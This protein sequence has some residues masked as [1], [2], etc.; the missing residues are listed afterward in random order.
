MWRARCFIGSYY[1]FVRP[2]VLG[3]EARGTVESLRDR[4]RPG[5]AYHGPTFRFELCE[6]FATRGPR[7]TKKRS[8]ICNSN[9]TKQDLDGR[10][11]ADEKIRRTCDRLARC[12]AQLA[13][14]AFG[15]QT[16]QTPRSWT[17]HVASYWASGPSIDARSKALRLSAER[18][19]WAHA[20]TAFDDKQRTPDARLKGLRNL[21]SVVRGCCASEPSEVPPWSS[22]S[23]RWETSEE[24]VARNVRESGVVARIAQVAKDDRRALRSGLHVIMLAAQRSTIAGE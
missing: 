7:E 20:L 23:T 10:W 2:G 6:A 9:N 12:L 22:R 11:D 17:Q 15:E 1:A 21:S 3:A 24:V 8:I 14:D 16:Q 5:R 13:P 4:L 18:F 19:V